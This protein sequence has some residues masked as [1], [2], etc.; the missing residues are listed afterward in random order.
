MSNQATKLCCPKC[1]ADKF[2]K[3]VALMS[4]L[5]IMCMCGNEFYAKINPEHLSAFPKY[6]YMQV[7]MPEFRLQKLFGEFIM[8]LANTKLGS[9]AMS[10]GKNLFVE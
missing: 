5:N 9:L 8:S 3:A 7:N 6:E 10:K 1:S 2:Y 4:G